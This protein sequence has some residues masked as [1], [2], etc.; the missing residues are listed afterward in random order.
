ML[1]DIINRRRLFFRAVFYF[2]MPQILAE[3]NDKDFNDLAFKIYVRQLVDFWNRG[4]LTNEE[5]ADKIIALRKK[6]I[7]EA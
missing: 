1:L 2:N 5:F 7:K 3:E 4:L 6:L